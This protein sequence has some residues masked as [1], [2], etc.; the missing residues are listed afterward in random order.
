MENWFIRYSKR[1]HSVLALWLIF[2]DDCLLIA[3]E[4]LVVGHNWPIFYHFHR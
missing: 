3:A 1:R 4:F 2:L